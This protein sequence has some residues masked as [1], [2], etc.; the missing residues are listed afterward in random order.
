MLIGRTDCECHCTWE[1]SAELAKLIQIFAKLRKAPTRLN[2][3]F[4]IRKHFAP[5]WEKLKISILRELIEVETCENF[6]IL[7][8]FERQMTAACKSMNRND[9]RVGKQ[10]ER[11]GESR[12]GRKVQE[13]EANYLNM[14][15][16]EVQFNE[17]PRRL[18][19][20][21][22]SKKENKRSE[23]KD[24]LRRERCSCLVII[25]SQ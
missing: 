11:E 22:W 15:P 4:R 18:R 13:A 17:M 23:V 24:E 6:I 25:T 10:E 12:R 21:A 1:V 19:F 5:C 2:I 20:S 14:N 9:F 8:Q 3:P 7:L 16:I